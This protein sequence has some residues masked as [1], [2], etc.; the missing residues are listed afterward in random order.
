M[1]KKKKT[2]SKLLNDDYTNISSDDQFRLLELG[3]RLMRG[4]SVGLF[5][6]GDK[7]P[8]PK[9]KLVVKEEREEDIFSGYNQS[10]VSAKSLVNNLIKT[11]MGVTTVEDVEEEEDEFDYEDK[12]LEDIVISDL[13]VSLS[14]IGKETE[15]GQIKEVDKQRL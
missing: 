2:K 7:K 5:G 1:G 6:T 13:T 3:E 14:Y 9:K 12:T 11:Q 15:Q 8:V 4:E 10:S